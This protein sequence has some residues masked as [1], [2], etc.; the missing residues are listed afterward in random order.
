M[1]NFTEEALKMFLKIAP[2]EL[3]T[4]D[5]AHQKQDWQSICD[6]AHKMKS[7]AVYCGAL[8]LRDACVNLEQYLRSNENS[9]HREKLYQVVLK[10]I[11]LVRKNNS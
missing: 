10:E 2:K 6:L 11:E 4:L 9:E 7:T 1:T 5:R 8:K 3:A